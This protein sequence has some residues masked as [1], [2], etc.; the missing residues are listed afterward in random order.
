[1][2]KGWRKIALIAL[3][4][5]SVGV[6]AACGDMA[7]ESDLQ[8]NQSYTLQME[9]VYAMAQEAGYEG[10]LEELIAL[11][12][13]EKG[14]QGVGVE[15]VEINTNGELIVALTNGKEINCGVIT[16]Q[17]CVHS[18]GNWMVFSNDAISCESRLLFRTCQD[19]KTVE[20]KQDEH[21]WDNQYS[22]DD[23]SH[24]YA[25]QKCDDTR[26]KEKHTVDGSGECSVCHELVGATEGVLYE[27]VD[28][29][30]RVVGYEGTHTKVRIAETYN[31][32][33]VK[34]IAEEAFFNCTSLTEIVLPESVTTIEFSAFYY[35]T[36][37]TKINIPESVTSIEDYAFYFC[38]SL[39]KMQIPEG[40]TEIG[41]HAFFRCDSLESVQ[42]PKSVTWIDEGAFAYCNRLTSITFNGTMAEWN[43]IQKSADWNFDIPATQVV[44]CDG[45]VTI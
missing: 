43:A 14:E 7:S 39:E 24:W 40:V 9:T 35:C 11:F 44:C 32:V 2:K 27:I 26:E 6:F 19:C 23:D 28:G 38:K 36:A 15:R 42:I 4:V 45:T 37:L 3:G 12:K 10:T 22:C 34:T 17:A 16:Q 25:C 8:E 31:G 20:W 30:A 21:S 29:V 13:G 33:A 1:M 18:F 41:D 5:A